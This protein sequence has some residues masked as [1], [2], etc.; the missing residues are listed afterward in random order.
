MT[1]PITYQPL[2]LRTYFL[3]V[4]GAM[5]TI[6]TPNAAIQVPVNRSENTHQL[7]NGGLAVTRRVASRRAWQ[8]TWSGLTPDLADQLVGYYTGVYGDG[9]FRFV[10]PAWRNALTVADSTF[11]AVVDSIGS[12]TWATS[13]SGAALTFDTTVAAPSPQ[14]GVLRW[15][16]VPNGGQLAPGSWDGG[17]FVPN[18]LAAV[19]YLPQVVTSIT[20]YG[21]ALTGTPNLSLRGRTQT[22]DGT[23]VGTVTASANMS[24]SVWTPLQVTVPSGQVASYVAPN[25]LCNTANSVVQLACPLV[26]YGKTP[27]D[28]WVI[29]LGVPRVIVAEAMPVQ[30][31]LLYARDHSL[32][33]AET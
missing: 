16:A 17:K 31:E 26:Q 30:Y 3:G 21:R 1:T 27:A 23:T 24:T 5:A 32:I 12:T 9:P 14:S 4:P 28:P 22:S 25:I 19:P 29:G 33:L 7:I 8:L 13:S 20:V 11:G 10:D 2:A 18:T 6:R 15:T